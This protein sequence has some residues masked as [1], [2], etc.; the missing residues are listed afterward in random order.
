MGWFVISLFKC[1]H[2][3]KFLHV[4]K[5]ATEID[6]ATY[7]DYYS[8]VSYHLMCLKCD[9]ILPPLTYAKSKLSTDAHI[10]LMREKG[11]L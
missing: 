11:D 7:P 8:H 10:K 9:A 2:P 5:D 1:K 4:A 6:S 3:F